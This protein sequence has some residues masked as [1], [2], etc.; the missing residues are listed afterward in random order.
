[1]KPQWDM[2]PEAELEIT[3]RNIN[4]TGRKHLSEMDQE[5]IENDNQRLLQEQE[6]AR[7]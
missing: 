4:I 6:L 1:M 7:A 2:Y 5:F 3:R